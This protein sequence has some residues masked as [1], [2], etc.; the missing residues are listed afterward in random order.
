[1]VVACRQNG[2]YRLSKMV[3][4]AKPEGRSEV[5]RPRLRWLDD[6]DNDITAVGVKR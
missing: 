1:M 3:F 5:G 2:R 6:V 4:N